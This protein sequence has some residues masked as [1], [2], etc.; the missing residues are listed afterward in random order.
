ML[1]ISDRRRF[2]AMMHNGSVY[3]G[4]ITLNRNVFLVLV[5]FIVYWFGPLRSSGFD[6]KSN[7]CVTLFQ[8]GSVA[9]Q[10]QKTVA[11][12]KACISE[13][14]TKEY[15]AFCMFLV[16]Y[17]QLIIL[18]GNIFYNVEHWKN[19]EHELQLTTQVRRR[20]VVGNILVIWTYS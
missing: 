4:S 17:L 6:K 12:W 10:K 18:I 13:W 2:G 3:F 5:F 20:A 11:F 16:I 7:R 14:N 1:G 8:N 19:N 15:N 9:K